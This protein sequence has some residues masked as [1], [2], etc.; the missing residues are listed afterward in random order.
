[1]IIADLKG[2]PMPTKTSASLV[3]IGLVLALIGLSGPHLDA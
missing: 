1:M 2:T 3:L